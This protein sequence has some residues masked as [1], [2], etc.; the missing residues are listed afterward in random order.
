MICGGRAQFI[1]WRFPKRSIPQYTSVSCTLVIWELFILFYIILHWCNM[2]FDCQDT[3][4]VELN[5]CNHRLGCE[6]RHQAVTESCQHQKGVTFSSF[7][8]IEMDVFPFFHINQRVLPLPG[9][10]GWRFCSQLCG[11]SRFFFGGVGNTKSQGSRLH[12]VKNHK[13]EFCC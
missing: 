4:W 3:V 1:P 2:L 6:L 11:K 7:F 10:I 5:L 12:H 8:G 13:F 9:W